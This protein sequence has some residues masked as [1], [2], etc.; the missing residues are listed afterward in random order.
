MRSNLP[1]CP[2]V[3]FMDHGP[4][5]HGI[6]CVFYDVVTRDTAGIFI[7]QSG[8]AWC[9]GYRLRTSFF[10]RGCGWWSGVTLRLSCGQSGGTGATIANRGE[11][12]RGVGGMVAGDLEKSYWFMHECMG[13][14]YETRMGREKGYIGW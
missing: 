6:R 8:S 3:G 2:S 14:A 10:G 4:V 9:G 5:V 13:L 7:D 11:A 12:E 1:I